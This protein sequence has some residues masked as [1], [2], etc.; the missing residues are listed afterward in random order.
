V[1]ADNFYARRLRQIK[2]GILGLTALFLTAVES[3]YYFIR[4]V[5]L[6]KDFVDWLIGMIF[7][8]ALIEIAFRATANLQK[9]NNQLL[10]EAIPDLMFRISKNGTFL[11]FW[12]AKNMNLIVPPDEFLGKK[13][14]E[15][16][17]QKEAQQ[18]MYYL[19]RTL[20]T[21]ET[22]IFEYQLTINGKI[23]DYEARYVASRED[24]VLAIV[25]DIT[26]YNRAKE[27]LRESEEHLRAVIAGAP[28]ILFAINCEGRITFLEGKGL[29]VLGIK[30]SESIGKPV[31]DV[32]RDIPELGKK[33]FRSLAGEETTLIAELTGRMFETRLS[34]LRALSGEITGVVG[35]AAD[36]T[37]SKRMEEELIRLSGA[38]NASV[39]G[40]VL[41]DINGKIIEVNEATL[42]MYGT[43]DKRDLIGKSAFDL[44]APEDRERAF[45]DMVEVLEKRYVKSREYYVITKNGEKIPVEMS[46]ALLEDSEGKP[47]G[48]V[49]ITRDITERFGMNK[50]K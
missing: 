10:L 43:D 22:Q 7:A 14:Y 35:V 21:R 1:N 47:I 28:I 17:P 39:D 20:Q 12:P 46:T 41:S 44:I 5:P 34:P 25:R 19:E 4:G 40:I 13:V 45:A 26:D 16:F 24:E 11:D 30:S 8:V 9:R 27:E 49:G 23:R 2:W 31:F 36:I 33:I 29:N 32:L 42:G 15:V 48:F 37:E 3:Y 38:V 18:I 6:I 50:Y